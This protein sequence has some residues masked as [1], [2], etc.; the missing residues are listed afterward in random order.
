MVISSISALAAHLQKLASDGASVPGAVGQCAEET[1]L[2]LER[3]MKWIDDGVV[4]E[5]RIIDVQFADFMSDPFATIGSIYER[6]GRELTPAAGKADARTSFGKP[7]RRRRRSHTWADTGLDAAELRERVRPTR[8]AST[9][10]PRR[11]VSKNQI[12]VD[13]G[14]KPSVRPYPAAMDILIMVLLLSIALLIWRGR[15]ADWSS[16]CGSS[17]RWRCSDCSSTTS[18]RCWI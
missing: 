11:C 1:I 15:S 12:S 9:F 17:V 5:D 2:G 7:G 10:P 6:M 8:S 3:T 4:G 13:T 18:P 14:T 16:G